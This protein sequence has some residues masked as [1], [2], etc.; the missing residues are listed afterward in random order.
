M[1]TPA[2]RAAMRARYCAPEYALLF[3]VGN[4]TGTQHRRW[5]DAVAMSLWP[6]RGLEL[7][8]FEFKA[9]RQD[10][11]KELKNPAKAEE[12]AQFCDRWYIV[13][14]QGIVKPEEVPAG[15][16][17][18]ELKHTKKQLALAAAGEDVD[19]PTLVMQKEAPRREAP[20]ALPRSFTAAML[21]RASEADAAEVEQ[22]VR[23]QTTQIRNQAREDAQRDLRRERDEHE[24]LRKR[25]AEFE[26]AAGFSIGNRWGSGGKEVGAALKLVLEH[27][28]GTIYGM[29]NQVGRQARDLVDSLDKLKAAL[30]AEKV[31]P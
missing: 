25:V 7:L 1:S 15:W 3:E 21:R 27:G 26:A 20:G 17:W 30:T 9:Y 11:L 23:R 4:A 31:E 6:S 13:S 29:F 10:W 24:A 16:G 12:I 19:P 2:I 28:P 18:L 22:I 5:A 8:G 14:A